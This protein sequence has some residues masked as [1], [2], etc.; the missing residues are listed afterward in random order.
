M[1]DLRVMTT[2]GEETILKEATV[3]QF[4]T[5]LRGALLRPG[6]DGY[7][8]ARKVFN[9]MID[10]RP[11]LIACCTGVADVITAVR[12]AR[13]HQVLVAVRGGGHHAAGHSVCEGGLVIDLSPM[14]G[15]RVDPIRQ[16]VH[17]Q[18]G[19]TWGEFDRETAAFGLAT[20]GGM[21]ST[22][23]IAGLTLGG[24]IGWLCRKY[25]LSCDNLL[26]ADVVTAEGTFLTANAREHADLF[27]GLRGGGGNFGLITAFEYRLHPV[28]QVLG[29]FLVYPL[30][31]AK[32]LLTFLREYLP[33]VPESLTVLIVFMTARADPMLPPAVHHTVVVAPAVCFTGPLSEEERV[34]RPLRT[35]GPPAMDVIGPMPYT[36]LQTLFDALEP[37]GFHRYWKSAY[38]PELSAGVL[39]AMIEGA[40]TMTSPLSHLHVM[41]LGGAISRVGEE[42]TAFSHRETPYECYIVDNWTNP[43]EA[44]RHLAW[45]RDTWSA[46]QAFSSGAGYLN[47]SSDEEEQTWL[48]MAYGARKYERL[49]ALKHTYDPTNV[50]R[51]NHNIKPTV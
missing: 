27:R 31:Q 11:A 22:T 36:A 13:A 6:D 51:L 25:G 29:G 30:A 28:A 18:G 1:A 15:V 48:R 3:Q 47:R 35:F 46:L 49:V 32:C 10:K 20:T 5:S 39:D 41:Q 45:A 21:I 50:F 7:D 2:T 43:E 44:D 42:D 33:T 14:K 34:L 8:P 9:A 38:V 17:A 16:T 23:G 19:V 40:A 12:F 26:S 37:P 24:G 4:Q